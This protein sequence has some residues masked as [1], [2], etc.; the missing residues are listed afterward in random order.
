MT[1]RPLT[2][3]DIALMETWLN[4][5]RIKR[6]Y[7]PI[8]EWLEEIRERQGKFAWLHDFIYM[9]GEAPVGFGRY[10]DCYDSVGLEDWPGRRFETPG[11]VYSIDYLIGDETYLGKGYG[12]ELVRLLTEAAFQCGAR[13][14]IVD[15]DSDN[16]PSNGALRANGYRF[17]AACGYFSL[18]ATS[19]IKS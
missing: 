15:P 12:A 7:D 9:D 2:D 3:A 18:L 4:Q 17:D 5:P 6:W 13:E 16:A 1:L 10:Y 19:F 11:E 14:I 8:E